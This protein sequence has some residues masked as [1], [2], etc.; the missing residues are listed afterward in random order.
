MN[1]ATHYY[2]RS[3]YLR[4]RGLGLTEQQIGSIATTGASTGASIATALAIGGAAGGPI[5]AA[6][7]AA[8]GI[9]GTLITNL[10]QPNVQKIQAS[11]DA[12]QIEPILQQNVANWFSIPTN[13]RYASVQAAA[14][15]VFNQAWAQYVSLVTPLLN[16]APNSIT[17][18][19]QGACHFHTAQPCGWQGNTFVSCG[20]NVSNGGY[21]WNWWVGY[22]DPIANDP[23][24]QPDSAASSA[25]SSSSSAAGDVSVA[26]VSIS[27]Y[28]LVGAGLLALALVTEAF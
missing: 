4:G 11:N 2:L 15:N 22:H 14:L 3:N 12:N 23:N 8:V 18:R 7:G 16:K 1:T 26:G 21:C 17:D 6:V 28:L 19:Q 5:G 25:S 9:I 13:Q 20:P 24:V 10:F 27:P